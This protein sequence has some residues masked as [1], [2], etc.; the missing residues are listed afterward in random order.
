MQEQEQAQERGEKEE[1]FVPPMERLREVVRA[2]ASQGALVAE[3]QE[4]IS[5]FLNSHVSETLLQLVLRYTDV[6]ETAKSKNFWSRGSWVPAAAVVE[7]VNADSISLSVSVRVRG[8]EAP[9]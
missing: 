8:K 5:E 9:E 6:G 7:A 2:Q 3:K 4:E 1:E